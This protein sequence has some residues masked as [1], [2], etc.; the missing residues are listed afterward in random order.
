MTKI[1]L[2]PAQREVIRERQR[3]FAAKKRAADPEAARAIVRASYEKHKAKYRAS[4][5]ALK[6]RPE[7]KAARRQ[8]NRER[9]RTDP[10]FKLAVLLRK[11]INQ[12]LKNRRK[13]T[14]A[15]AALE[16]TV[17]ELRAYLADKFVPGMSWENH[18]EWHIDHIKPLASFD[19]EDAIQYAEACHYTNLQPLWKLDNLSKGAKIL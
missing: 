16:Y 2:T 14:S 11:R 12:A 1:D 3:V 18:G 19:L 6:A 8:R 5:N 13:V 9:W 15:I 10:E 7:V 17:E 4:D